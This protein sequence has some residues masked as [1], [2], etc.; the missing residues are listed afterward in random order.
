MIHMLSIML[1]SWSWLSFMAKMLRP[2]A[3]ICG[4]LGTHYGEHK[5][6]DSKL[7]IARLLHKN[8]DDFGCR[9]E[10]SP[11]EDPILKSFQCQ[12]MLSQNLAVAGA[13]VAVDHVQ[14]ARLMC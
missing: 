10:C 13:Y 14:G 12:Q 5:M 1:R 3:M 2:L 9:L 8:E 6:L 4:P 11:K 7:G